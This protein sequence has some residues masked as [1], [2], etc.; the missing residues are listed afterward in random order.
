M[1]GLPTLTGGGLTL[2]P[3][4]DADLP[5]LAEFLAD[6]SVARWFGKD[7]ID[8]L[9]AG[10]DQIWTILAGKKV[11]GWLLEEEERH[12]DY[13]AASLDIMLGPPFQGRGLGPDVLRLALTWLFGERGHH[14]CTI[15]PAAANARAIAAYRKV[16]FREVGI[17]RA[18]TRTPDGGWE[19][20]LMMD[21]L[22]S[23]LEPLGDQL[24]Q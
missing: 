15:D 4:V 17:M 5:Q 20:S 18:A 6:P 7:T 8:D 2:R 1:T 14:R 10:D 21:L 11:A 22:A 23:E 3:Q 19:D 9:R 13:M 16:G 12:P 24:S